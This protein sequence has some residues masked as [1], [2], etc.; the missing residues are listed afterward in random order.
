[1]IYLQLNK[2]E[3][4]KT[5]KRNPNSFKHFVQFPITQIL[6]TQENL[7]RG[8]F[9]EFKNELTRANAHIGG[10]GD[11]ILKVSFESTDSVKSKNKWI[12]IMMKYT[13]S[14]YRIVWDISEMPS[15]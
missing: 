10:Y 5:R 14:V 2:L 1:M 8:S 15:H 4:M 3:T 6:F 9:E 7:R 12:Q 11:T 13:D